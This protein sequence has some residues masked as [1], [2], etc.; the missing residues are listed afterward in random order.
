MAH[1][2]AGAPF[3]MRFAGI[4]RPEQFRTVT[5]A[6]L[7]AWRDELGRRGFGGATIPHRLASLA[8]RIEH[9]CEKNA[10]THN[11]VKGSS[12]RRP[13][14]AKARHRRSATTRRAT[15]LPHAAR[16]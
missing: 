3:P 6:H 13:K 8:S 15:C 11:P 1:L 12:G 7:I 4:R 2:P 16:G 14:A 10:V 9:L 5:R